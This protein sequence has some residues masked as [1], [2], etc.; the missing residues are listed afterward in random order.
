MNLILMP[1]TLEAIDQ[2]GMLSPDGRCY[3]FDERANGMVP[4]KRW[5]WWC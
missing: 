4:G 3:A 2:A 5:R 1:Q